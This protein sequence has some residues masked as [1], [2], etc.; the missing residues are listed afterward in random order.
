MLCKPRSSFHHWSKIFNRVGCN[1]TLFNFVVVCW[2]K[3]NRLGKQREYQEKVNNTIQLSSH[4]DLEGALADWRRRMMT[5]TRKQI[6]CP[7]GF[8]TNLTRCGVLI[9]WEIL[10]SNCSLLLWRWPHITCTTI[11]LQLWEWNNSPVST[12]SP[13]LS[14]LSVIAAKH[15]RN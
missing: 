4:F 8:K 10:C 11:T 12:S 6:S 13:L 5:R 15:F 1:F 2:W 14:S 9:V 3:W 7:A